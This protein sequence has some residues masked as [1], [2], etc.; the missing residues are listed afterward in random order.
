MI[1]ISQTEAVVIDATGQATIR[2]TPSCVACGQPSSTEF[3]TRPE[4]LTYGS[5]AIA[6]GGSIISDSGFRPMTG[7]QHAA[8]VADALAVEHAA[9]DGCGTG[10]DGFPC[11]PAY[12]CPACV[13]QL[14]ATGGE[15]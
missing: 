15:L 3:C 1:R 7:E 11:S 2:T 6:A 10:S 12:L 4:C 5:G 9:G 14:L 13:A 8:A